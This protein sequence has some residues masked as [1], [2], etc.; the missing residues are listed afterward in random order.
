LEDT[1]T[2]LPADGERVCLMALVSQCAASCGARLHPPVTI[3]ETEDAPTTKRDEDMP[4]EQI[5]TAFRRSSC[6]SFYE[7]HVVPYLVHFSM[8]QERLEPYRRRAVLTAKG[9][10]LEIGVGSGINLRFYPDAT[11]RVIGVDPSRK[12]LTMAQA[13]T[14][15]PTSSVELIE[16]SAEALPLED[17]S[18]DTVVSTWTLCS[19][20]DVQRALL[21]LRRVLRRDGRLLFVEHGQASEEKISRWQQRLTPIWKRFAGGCHLD[22]PIGTLIE[23]AG[24]EIDRLDTGYMEGPKLLTFLYEGAAYPK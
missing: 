21:E 15:R 11:T 6:V 17:S 1:T 8:R 9:R 10:V 20:P 4:V 7:R 3:S 23:N 19:I 14:E 24:F 12:L 2:R 5:Q 18:V 16:G 22:R 13:A